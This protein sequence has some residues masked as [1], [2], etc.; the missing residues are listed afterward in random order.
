MGLSNSVTGSAVITETIPFDDSLLER[1]TLPEGFQVNV[2]ARGLVNARML[3][4]APDGTLF[5]TRR[6]EGDLIALMDTNGDG[7][8]DSPDVNVVVSDLTFLHEIT[9]RG[10]QLYLANP[11]KIFVADWL[12][13]D[14]IS[15]LR[16]IISDLSAVGQHPNSTMAFGPDRLL[17]HRG[18]H[19]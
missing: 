6:D 13:G 8:A 17:C 5:V 11:T 19:L 18:Q 4:V 15:E 2:F 12:G 16:K 14:A 1:L 10:N 3:A 7:I 9:F